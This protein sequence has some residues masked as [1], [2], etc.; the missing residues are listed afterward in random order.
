ME[1]K[2]KL[3]SR[4]QSHGVEVKVKVSHRVKVKVMESKSWSQSQSHGVMKN[5]NDLCW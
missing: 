3:W 5:K 1:S 2:S 4:S